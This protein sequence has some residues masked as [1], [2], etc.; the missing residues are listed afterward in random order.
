MD[1]TSLIPDNLSELLVKIIQFTES[2]RSVLY[3]NIYETRSFG[4]APQDMPILEFVHALNGAV[5]EHVENH[6]LLLRDTQNIKF[7]RNGV[8]SLCPV[9]DKHAEALLHTNRSEY[10]EYQVN[11]LL[12]NSLNR[13]VA[14]ELLKLRCGVCS[15]PDHF[16]ASHVRAEDGPLQ[17]SSASCGNAE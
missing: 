16:H 11:K 15:G 6:R 1:L 9:P 4:F 7:G 3:Q 5:A 13:R 14:Q 2:R 17:D 10:L 8:M 12:E